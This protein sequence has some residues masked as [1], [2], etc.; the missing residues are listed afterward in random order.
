MKNR[1]FI[2]DERIPFQQRLHRV[3]KYQM[4]N[5]PVYRVFYET[6]TSQN[7]ESVKP[8]Q[9]PR[10]P[11][12]AFKESKIA[13]FD[14][15][16]AELV[17]RSSGT[18]NM[19]RSV[20]YLKY[21]SLYLESVRNG[22]DTFYNHRDY[23]IWC[24]TPAY[25]DNPDSS[26][27]YMLRKLI[28]WDR[29]GQS[30]FLPLNKGLEPEKI[31]EVS[32]S[33]KKLMLFGAAFGLL[34]LLNLN[35]VKLPEDSVV[36][37][38]GGMKTYR[39]EMGKEELHRTLADGFGLPLTQIHSE[40]GM[41]ELLSQAYARENAWFQTPHWMQVTIHDPSDPMRLCE[42]GEEGKIGVIDLANLFS[43]SFILTDD[44]G[45]MDKKGRFRVLGRWYSA[46]L[47]GCNFLIDRD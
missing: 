8:E 44:V 15:R 25:H 2:F 6:I 24:Y 26:L 30:R 41:C 19:N 43:C 23:T 13:S 27:I 33:G 42:D 36:I 22:F 11:V 45:I 40:Y 34:D 29:S 3:L 28:E 4:E 21:S 16:E 39:R 9:I 12:R 38:T 5:N 31:Q 7:I 18:G 35:R 37:E 1:N 20:H 17:F 47:R 32:E 14:S 46:D 10:L